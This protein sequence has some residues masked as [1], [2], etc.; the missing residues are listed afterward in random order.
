MRCKLFPLVMALAFSVSGGA[1]AASAR[2]AVAPAKA[3]ALT[4]IDFAH[5]LNHG[6]AERLGALVE[7]FNSQNKDVHI[8]LVQAE[9]HGKPAPLNLATTDT[10]ANFT[11]SPSSFKPCTS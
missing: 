7:R 4:E 3:P 6:N 8:N 9:A 10:V 11:S 1:L 5:Q 2:K